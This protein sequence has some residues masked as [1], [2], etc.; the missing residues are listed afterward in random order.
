MQVSNIPEFHFSRHILATVHFNYNLH[1][2]EK[3]FADGSVHVSVRYP[4]F[5][6]DEAVV[7]SVR[8]AANFS[9]LPCGRK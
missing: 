7:R 4:K 1:R 5:K 3:K 6:N 8:V 9:K 2:E